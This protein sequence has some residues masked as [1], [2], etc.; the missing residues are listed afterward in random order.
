MIGQLA[1]IG[2]TGGHAVWRDFDVR[3]GPDYDVHVLPMTTG[4][5]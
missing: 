4:G 5:S 3:V 1:Q 2:A